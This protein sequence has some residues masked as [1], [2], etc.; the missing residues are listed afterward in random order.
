MAWQVNTVVVASHTQSQ[1]AHFRMQMRLRKLPAGTLAHLC[2]HARACV[3]DGQFELNIP[4]NRW[5]IDIAQVS[6]VFIPVSIEAV[7]DSAKAL[8]AG[9]AR[10]MTAEMKAKRFGISNK[11]K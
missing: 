3:R 11:H 2:M 7:R 8:V 4:G 1:T 5:G 9:A 10:L 6:T